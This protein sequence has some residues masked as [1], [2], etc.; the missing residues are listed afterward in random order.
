MPDP[1]HQGFSG[2]CGDFEL[3]RPLG[4][5]LHDDGAARHLVTMAYVANF[6]CDQV[7]PTQLA[8]DAQIEKCK[9]PRTPFH[10][11]A[12]SECPDVLWFEWCLLAND[13]PLVPRLMMSG[14]SYC[15][16]D[17]LPSS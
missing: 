7:T 5:L 9:F 6:E 13:F 12:N 15:F 10:L 1:R 2:G 17:G 16:H 4:F 14:V 8:I 11:E 3:N